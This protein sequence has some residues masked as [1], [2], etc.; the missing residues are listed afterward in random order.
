MAA[1]RGSAVHCQQCTPRG[2]TGVR[3]MTLPLL[4]ALDE[5]LH[6]CVLV[7]LLTV[8]RNQANAECNSFGF[9]VALIAALE[10]HSCMG[11]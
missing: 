6:S 7:T 4:L 2:P 1:L 3:E 10:V 9:S 11:M 5:S 8:V